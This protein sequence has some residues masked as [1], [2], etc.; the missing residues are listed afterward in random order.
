MARKKSGKGRLKNTGSTL[1]RNQKTKSTGLGDTVEKVFKA[2]GIDKA[3]KFIAGEDCGCSD[4][5]EI[6]NKVFPYQKPECLNEKEYNFLSKF[7]ETRHPQIKPNEQEALL[8]VYNR[9]FK[10]NVEMT[11]CGSCFLNNVY[12][13]LERVYKE[14]DKQ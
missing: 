1:N 8:D 3:V 13:K 9:I 14:Y 6:L 12:K 7:F 5:R 4:R 11:S 2:V 10:D